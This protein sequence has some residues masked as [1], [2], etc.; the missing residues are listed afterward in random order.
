MAER[1]EWILPVDTR[2]TATVDG[3][4]RVESVWVGDKLH[5]RFPHG[6]AHGR[7]RIPLPPP[8]PELAAGAYRTADRPGEADVVV[9]PNGGCRLELGGQLVSPA[10]W[11]KPKVPVASARPPR[12]PRFVWLCACLLLQV[13]AAAVKSGAHRVSS[14]P[15]PPSPPIELP[16]EPLSQI[17]ASTDGSIS[18]FHPADF[19]AITGTSAVRLVRPELAEEMIFVSEPVELSRGPKEAR[20]EEAHRRLFAVAMHLDSESGK[21]VAVPTK[22]VPT[23]CH[24]FPGVGST[25]QLQVRPNGGGPIRLRLD[26]C[27]TTLHDRAYFIATVV[28]EMLELHDRALFRRIDHVA[29]LSTAAWHP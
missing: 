2:I 13:C 9:S 15:R 10:R 3:D 12:S 5:A 19:L 11:P 17:A 8:P 24:G 18:V 20:G 28:P 22:L 4:H 29:E 14:I 26:A 21:Q 23:T 1:W 25:T 27:T 7:Y 6:A 16:A